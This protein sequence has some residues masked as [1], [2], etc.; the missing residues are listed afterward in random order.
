MDAIDAEGKWPTL[1]QKF[2]IGRDMR[3]EYLAHTVA[4]AKNHHDP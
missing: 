2:P 1:E 4:N 3:N